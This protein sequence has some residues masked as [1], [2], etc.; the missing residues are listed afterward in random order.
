M[1]ILIRHSQTQILQKKTLVLKRLLIKELTMLIF[2]EDM[3]YGVVASFEE[4]PIPRIGE[5]LET[6]IH[7]EFSTLENENDTLKGTVTNVLHR[8]VD[9]TEWITIYFNGTKV[10]S[11]V[12]R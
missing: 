4:I 2:F 5:T 1:S 3:R 6:D 9:E 8:Y 10:L 11:D 12:E 7:E